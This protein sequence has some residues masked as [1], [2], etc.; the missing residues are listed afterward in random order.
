MIIWSW[1]KR[2]RSFFSFLELLRKKFEADVYFCLAE[3]CVRGERKISKAKC[4]IPESRKNNRR[5]A[6]WGVVSRSQN[7]N[8]RWRWKG[9]RLTLGTE[10]R[11]LN[12]NSLGCRETTKKSRWYTLVG[13]MRDMRAVSARFI[14]ALR[15]TL[16]QFLYSYLK[17][18][19]C[20]HHKLSS[21]QIF[22]VRKQ[23]S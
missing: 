5:G 16:H 20:E 14:Y 3:G 17:K 23:H 1:D 15:N 4:G 18:V 12:I 10:Q 8:S 22:D 7:R 6:G 21:I 11:N 2:R 9:Y 13:Y 19:L